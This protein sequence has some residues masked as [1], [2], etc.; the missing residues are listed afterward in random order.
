MVSVGKL[1][2]E[3][4]SALEQAGIGTARLD[5]LVLL[6]DVTGRD[7]AWLL[8][9]PE[10][11]LAAPERAKL[12]KL[13]KLRAEHMPL[14]YIR[15]RTEFYGRNFVINP[16]VLEPRPESETMIDMLGKL[17]ASGK[18]KPGG[19]YKAPKTLKI[20][21]VGTGSGAL[22]ITAELEL[23][24]SSK[25]AVDLLDIDPGALEV[26]KM[27][28]E[29]Y[30]TNISVI[31]SDLLED[32]AKDYDVLLCNLPYVPDGHT[33]NRA[34][35]QEPKLAVFGGPD[36]LDIYRRLF[37]QV[38]ELRK[39]PLY[40]LTE[41]LPPQHGTLASI[42]RDAGYGLERE[43]DFIQLFALSATDPVRSAEL[44]EKSV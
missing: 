28:V 38:N 18:F 35:M 36:G 26:A 32:T 21:D 10:H 17:P 24:R 13:L 33:V 39:K 3:A 27:N 7:R 15:G 23:S 41:A 42:A 11:R 4:T 2:E 6:E 34:A 5:A 44:H 9:H 14:A 25:V 20:A 40:I 22:G 30:T 12:T 37:G 29:K 8:A 31:R 43:D 19:P 16:A 1:L